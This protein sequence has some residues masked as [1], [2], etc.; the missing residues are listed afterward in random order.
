[1]TSA[2]ESASATF[3]EGGGE[4]GALMRSF[5]WAKT[6]LG[7][8]AGW[9]QSLRT[10]VRIMLTSRQPFWIGYGPEL[11]YM[12]NDPYKSII[13]GKHPDALGRPFSE[14][15][16]EIWHVVGPMAEHVIGRDEGTYV[17]S[18]RLIM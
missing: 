5:D 10:A 15:W 18:Q 4:L 11:T 7:P 9:P 2:T 13:G 14:V 1:M 8:P 12:Y 3:L 16:R 6:P 17:E